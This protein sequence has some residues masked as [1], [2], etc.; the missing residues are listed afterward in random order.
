[1][2]GPDRA[3][4]VRAY[5]VA[6]VATALGL[7]VRG[8]GRLVSLS[9][10]PACGD[11]V[12]GH[13]RPDRRGPVGLTPDGHGWRCHRCREGG[14]AVTLA[15]WFVTSSGAPRGDRFLDVLAT[16][17]GHGLC[18]P[19]PGRTTPKVARRPPPPPRP[20]LP[21]QRPPVDELAAL[22]RAC[23]PVT[24]D[25]EVSAWLTSRGLDP[26][27]VADRELAYALP[28][29]A[30]L[31]AWARIHGRA[32]AEAGYRCALPLYG[33]SGAAESVRGR[34]VDAEAHPKTANPAGLQIAGTVL[35]DPLARS[36][37]AG[38]VDSRELVAR[39]GLVV[40]EGDPDFLTWATA[41]GEA[42]EDAPAVVGLVEGGWTAEVAAAVPDG[43]RVAVRT[44]HDDNGDRYAAQVAATLGRR[45]RVLR[46]RKEPTA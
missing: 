42:D 25:A 38:D 24:A 27:A 41:R 6:E 37:L 10:C 9:P 43:T 32:W 15:A 23:L 30:S 16:C 11:D 44:H 39:V 3:A 1:M 19:L 40:A 35:A 7:E 22:W 8:R 12:R 36:M 28:P 31:P 46:P 26:Q 17:A 29:G 20:V 4:Q 14:D 2:T 34:A 45:C 5:P 13:T 21:P 33:S 18:D